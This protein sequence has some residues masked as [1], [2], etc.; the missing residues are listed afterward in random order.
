MHLPPIASENEYTTL[1]EELEPWRPAVGE[2]LRRHGL[3]FADDSLRLGGASTYPTV[4]VGHQHVVKLFGPWWCG[5]ESLEAESA[6]YALLD[7]SG[8]PIPALRGQGALRDDWHYLLLGQLR[9][10]DIA[11]EREHLDGDALVNI[12]RWLGRF[13]HDLR[14]IALPAEGYLSG[15]WSRF[16]GFLSERCEE[17]IH[18]PSEESRLPAHL[19]AELADWLP[20][21][22]DLIDASRSPALLHGDLHDHHVL[23]TVKGSAFVPNGVIDFTDALAGDPYYEIGPLHLHTFRADRRLLAAWLAEARLPPA[24]P[25]GF[26]RRALAFTLLHEFDPIDRLRDEIAGLQTLDAVADELFG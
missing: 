6:A 17:L 20:Q 14:R 1:L 13:C 24:G 9:G 7:G 3:T 10:S 19:H 2:V 15:S 21:V 16:H 23:G 22:D 4:L 18:R 26:R 25:L 11:A 12:A 5:P 8:L